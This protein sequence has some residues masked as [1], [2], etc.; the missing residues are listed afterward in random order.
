MADEI[1]QLQKQPQKQADS[2][3]ASQQNISNNISADYVKNI[4][5]KYLEFMATGENMK[6]ALTIEKVLFSIVDATPEDL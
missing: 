6:E 2:G 3:S 5:L 4:L 1:S